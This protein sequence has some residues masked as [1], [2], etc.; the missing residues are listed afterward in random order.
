MEISEFGA[1]CVREG[2]AGRHDAVEAV[3]QWS[4]AT[5]QLTIV[6]FAVGLKGNDN[7]RQDNDLGAHLRDFFSLGGNPI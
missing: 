2:A 1:Q 6:L 4:L 3:D 5:G 7:L